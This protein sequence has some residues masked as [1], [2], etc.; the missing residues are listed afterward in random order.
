VRD[1]VNSISAETLVVV[2][3][4]DRVV[5]PDNSRWLADKIPNAH[6]ETIEGAGHMIPTETPEKLAALITRFMQA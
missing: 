2:G 4:D 6:L 3:T 5:S 1:R